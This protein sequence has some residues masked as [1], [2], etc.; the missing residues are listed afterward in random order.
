MNERV[1]TVP[2]AAAQ[3]SI[4][5]AMFATQL[6]ALLERAQP[7]LLRLARAFGITGDEAHDIVQETQIQAWRR[8]G[9]LRSAG[10]F[11]AWLD[12]ICR[13]QCRMFVRAN[14]GACRPPRALPEREPDGGWSQAAWAGG[15]DS[16][17]GWAA[18]A[19]ANDPADELERQELADLVDR[20]LA[21]LPAQARQA[22][23]LRYLHGWAVAK[24]AASLDTSI[25]AQEMRLRRAR[26][27]LREALLGPLRDEAAAFG[28]VNSANV[29][30][31]GASTEWQTTRITCYLCGRHALQG[32]FE[33][34]ANGRRELRLRCPACSPREGVDVFRSKG[35][36]PLDGLRTFRPAMTRAVRSL[37]AYGLRA[38]AS[39]YDACLHCGA[40][41]R[42]EVVG[43]E[44]YP[45]ALPG[46]ARRHW[47]VARCPRAGC[48]GLGAWSAAEP[49]LWSTPAVRQFMADHP[50]WLLGPEDQVDWQ[51]RRA[52]LL[53]V[54][55]DV[56]AARL[57]VAAD[58]Q[59]LDVLAVVEG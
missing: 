17:G 57:A 35:L 9:Q 5:A 56:G 53:R 23:E 36:A 28:L 22:L 29:C 41:V 48:A 18:S 32:R 8:L 49:V 16:A 42:R 50:R 12:A 45:D 37:H 27:Q 15:P 21:Y 54:A 52:I 43:T 40:D 47:L 6:D 58:A 13:N 55:D 10:R 46:K 30:D 59:T 19:V 51:G 31:G 20:A 44:A 11:T 4:D 7:R 24:V 26:T 33:P 25:A 14:A 34:A 2:S 39:G 3:E 1:P 38:L